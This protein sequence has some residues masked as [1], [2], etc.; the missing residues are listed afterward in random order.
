MECL[1][2]V[3]TVKL[4]LHI[5]LPHYFGVAFIGLTAGI[6]AAKALVQHLCECFNDPDKLHV[7]ILSVQ[8]PYR[9]KFCIQEVLMHI[10][11]PCFYPHAVFGSGDTDREVTRPKL[12]IHD[13]SVDV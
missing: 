4:F 5:R 9:R 13:F 7:F 10:C 3:A 12:L 11:L 8:I 6:Y 1:T 2:K